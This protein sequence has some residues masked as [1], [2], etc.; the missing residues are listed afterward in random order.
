MTQFS[1]VNWLQEWRTR[2]KNQTTNRHQELFFS[3]FLLFHFLKLLLFSEIIKHFSSLREKDSIEQKKI[4]C[5]RYGL[6]SCFSTKI[7]SNISHNVP[8][9][10]A[11]CEVRIELKSGNEGRLEVDL[12]FNPSLKSSFV[13]YWNVLQIKIQNLCILSC[14]K[15]V[16]KSGSILMNVLV[17]WWVSSLKFDTHLVSLSIFTWK[18]STDSTL[19]INSLH[20]EWRNCYYWLC[21]LLLGR[22]YCLSS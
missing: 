18:V 5:R 10:N 19:L 1:F 6:S 13:S 22:R 11:S 16:D 7:W 2:Q 9:K 21:V 8:R 15:F 14:T 20:C 4:Y 3:F 17:F 12:K